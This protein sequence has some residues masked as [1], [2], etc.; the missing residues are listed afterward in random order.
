[1]KPSWDTAPSWANYLAMD[2]DGEWRWFEYEPYST[3][4]FW[5]LRKGRSMSA[6][7][8]IN[9]DESLEERPK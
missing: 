9:W 2:E 6:S 8:A 5:A 3:T 1:M 7:E 4:S